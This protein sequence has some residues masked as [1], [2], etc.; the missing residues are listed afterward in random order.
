MTFIFF[1]IERKHLSEPCQI[2][3][4]C[5]GNGNAICGENNTCVCDKG[6]VRVQDKCVL[7]KNQRKRGGGGRSVTP[8]NLTTAFYVLMLGWAS[9]NAHYIENMEFQGLQAATA[10]FL[11]FYDINNRVRPSRH[12]EQFTVSFILP[13]PLTLSADNT[14]YTSIEFPNAPLYA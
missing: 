10:H 11:T 5:S 7:G 1:F 9:K 3:V 12:F 6:N 4:Q 13:V 2:H 8:L 14:C